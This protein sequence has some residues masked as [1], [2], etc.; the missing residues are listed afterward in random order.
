MLS[1]IHYLVI[2]S[3]D[4]N[5]FAHAI[6]RTIIYLT[7]KN[8]YILS[9]FNICLHTYIYRTDTAYDDALI[10][11]LF[12]FMFINS[13]ASMYYIAFI[14]ANLGGCKD[15]S[16]MVELATQLAT[17]FISQMTVSKFISYFQLVV[18]AK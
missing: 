10:V 8:I 13:Y 11:K 3:I 4:F 5:S 9:N 16:C 18:K 12:V 15:G 1:F 14:K 17:L 2:Y 7:I 6:Y